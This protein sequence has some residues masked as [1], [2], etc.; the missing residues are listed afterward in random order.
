MHGESI[1]LGVLSYDTQTQESF[2]GLHG[3]V[4]LPF[5]W[6]DSARMDD[7]YRNL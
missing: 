1:P 7:P 4:F 5:W 6:C 2:L 3:Y